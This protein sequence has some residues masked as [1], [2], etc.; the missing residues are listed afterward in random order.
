MCRNKHVFHIG[1]AFTQQNISSKY[2]CQTH[3]FYIK[4]ES[5]QQNGL[6]WFNQYTIHFISC[7]CYSKIFSK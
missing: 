3:V 4:D 6:N 2:L 1:A 7:N 5:F